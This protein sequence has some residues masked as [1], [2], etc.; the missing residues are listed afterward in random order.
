[1]A[2]RRLSFFSLIN[3]CIMFL[4]SKSVTWLVKCKKYPSFHPSE[5][6][7]RQTRWSK[8]QKHIVH[9]HEKQKKPESSQTSGAE[10]SESWN[11]VA[12][13]RYN[14]NH[15][16]FLLISLAC[17]HFLISFLT[18]CAPEIFQAQTGTNWHF[19]DGTL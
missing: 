15:S 8:I 19:N 5:L 11:I 1:M 10:T 9:Y 17:Q 2:K 3:L 16:H 4:I 6:L 14:I 13:L 12:V 7:S 18:W